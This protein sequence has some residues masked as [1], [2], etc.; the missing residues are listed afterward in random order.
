MTEKAQAML[1]GLKCEA[2]EKKHK[3]LKSSKGLRTTEHL[4]FRTHLKTDGKKG[5]LW[6]RNCLFDRLRLKGLFPLKGVV[7]VLQQRQCQ[8]LFATDCLLYGYSPVNVQGWVGQLDAA[9]RLWGVIVVALVLE[10]GGFREHRETVGKAVRD[11]ELEVV[12][13]RQFHSHML[14][15]SGRPHAYVHS[16]IE[17]SSAHAT[18]QFC[19]REWRPLE[20]QPTNHTVGRHALVVLNELDGCHFLLKLSLGE[21]FEEITAWVVKDAWLDN[22]QARYRGFDDVHYWKIEI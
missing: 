8:V 1:Q 10:H 20:V 11:K 13:C 9:F 7:H 15:E 18:D 5:S 2:S 14:A 21:G 3:A 4:I 17:H 22:E 19:L 16:H 6:V 12:L